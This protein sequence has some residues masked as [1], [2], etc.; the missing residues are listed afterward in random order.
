MA[1]GWSFGR[2]QARVWWLREGEAGLSAQAQAISGLF[3]CRPT[4]TPLAAR[5]VLRPMTDDG[6]PLC[7]FA[8]GQPG[9][10][11]LLAHPGVILGP[12]LA[13][14]AGQEIGVAFG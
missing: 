12:W 9:L 4:I 5:Q 14:R 8:R 2:P 7:G 6:E 13:R 10:Y 3:G 1:R 11:L